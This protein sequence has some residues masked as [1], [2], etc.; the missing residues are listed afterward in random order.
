MS[1]KWTEAQ[2]AAIKIHHKTLLVSAAAGSGK[3]ATLTERIIRSITDPDSPA[4]VSR[5]LIVT[6]TRAAA[7]E[8]KTRIFHALSEALAKNPTNRYLASQLV[9]LGSARICTIDSFCLDLLRSN[10]SLLGLPASF[11]I[12]DETEI[13]LLSHSVMEEVIDFFYE[14]DNAFPAFAECFTGTRNTDRLTN[15]LIDLA[16]KPEFSPSVKK[17]S[18]K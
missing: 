8:L 7:E 10:F 18:Y 16:E 3:T 6:F 9:K 17:R 2:S 1:R 15:L 13:E 14:N 12:A 4:D 5:M 11:R